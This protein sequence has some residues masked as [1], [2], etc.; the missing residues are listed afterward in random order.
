ME[1]SFLKSARVDKVHI[2]GLSRTKDDIVKAQVKSL[3]A[4]QSIADV[5]KQSTV[6]MEKL[7]SLGCFRNIGVTIDTSKGPSASH[8]GVE[9]Y[10]KKIRKHSSYLNKKRNTVKLHQKMFTIEILFYKLYT[11]I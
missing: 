8:D 7:E 4:A 3:F 10:L 2:N 5:I 11:E 1:K 6:V 9:V